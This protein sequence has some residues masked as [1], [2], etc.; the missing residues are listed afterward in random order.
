MVNGRPCGNRACFLKPPVIK[1]ELADGVFTVACT[2]GIIH[3]ILYC[4]LLTINLTGFDFNPAFYFNQQTR[5]V[6]IPGLL[7]V[8]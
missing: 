2:G 7:I 1:K 6:L 4:F 5:Q 8:C 3:L